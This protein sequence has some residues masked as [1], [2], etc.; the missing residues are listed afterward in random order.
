MPGF[1]LPRTCRRAVLAQLIDDLLKV[2]MER[3]ANGGVRRCDCLLASR[4]SNGE[5]ARK[6]VQGP[7]RSCLGWARSRAC[8]Q[9]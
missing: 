8:A 1:S 6:E 4:A 9:A 7:L 2:P 3:P 5:Q